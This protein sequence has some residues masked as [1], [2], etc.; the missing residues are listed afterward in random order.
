MLRVKSIVEHVLDSVLKC[1]CTILAGTPSFSSLLGNP[2]EQSP[3]PVITGADDEGNTARSSG[4]PSPQSPQ[5]MA[6]M[7]GVTRM[8]G[9]RCHPRLL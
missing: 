9:V 8:T 7:T 2:E 3:S 4:F 6:V 1:N 5:P